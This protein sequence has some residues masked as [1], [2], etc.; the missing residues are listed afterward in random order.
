VAAQARFKRKKNLSVRLLS[1]PDRTLLRAL[2]A[3]A[4]IRLLGIR[5]TRTIR[6]TFVFDEQGRLIRHYPRV[7]IK[8]HAEAVLA[9]LG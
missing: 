5:K 9:D 2:G 4:E 6:S 1:D 8:G 3:V 7:K